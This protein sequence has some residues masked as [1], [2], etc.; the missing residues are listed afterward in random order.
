[1]IAVSPFSCTLLNIPFPIGDT[2]SA[3]I[4]QPVAVI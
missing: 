2:P 4:D 3:G 1:M